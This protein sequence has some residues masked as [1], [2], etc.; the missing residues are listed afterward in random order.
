MIK[1]FIIEDHPPITAGLRNMF[2]PERDKICIAGSAENINEALLNA[3]KTTFDIFLFDL[4]LSKGFPL[5]NFELIKTK[6][7][8]K[9]N[10]VYTG[11][12]STLWQRRMYNAGAAAYIV[13]TSNRPEMKLIIEKVA[14]GETVFP[15]E[16][17]KNLGKRIYFSNETQQFKLNANQQNIVDLLSEGCTQRKIAEIKQVSES[18]MEKTIKHIRELFGAKNNAELVNILSKEKTTD[19]KS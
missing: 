3:D 8:D 5:D 7:P 14:E 4:W 19:R 1:L 2:R 12:T 6:F 18:T 16:I 11:E 17:K 9:P 10:I 15:A 13:K